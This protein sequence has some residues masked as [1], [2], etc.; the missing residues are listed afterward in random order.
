MIDIRGRVAAN[1][2]LHVGLLLVTIKLTID[3]LLCN[4]V[5]PRPWW[6]LAQWLNVAGGLGPD[7]DDLGWL[8]LAAIALPF[9]AIGVALTIRRLRDAGCSPWLAVL[10][11]LPVVNWVMFV[12]LAIAPSAPAPMPTDA[13]AARPVAAEV[14]W[15]R[16]G[17][18]PLVW[19]NAAVVAVIALAIGPF[20]HY[21]QALFLGAPFVQG[22]VAGALGGADGNRALRSWL[23]SVG[24]VVLLLIGLAAEGLFCIAMAAPIWLAFGLLGFLFG[25]ALQRLER[26]GA[27]AGLL[28]LPLLHALEPLVS[29]PPSTFEVTTEVVV[30]AAPERVWDRLVTFGAMAP[31]TEWWFRA[32][33]AYPT[34]ATIDGR[35]VGAVRRC[36]FNTGDFVEP[37]E[38]WDEPRLLRFRVEQC[39]QP[40]IEWNPLHDHVHAAHLHGFFAARRGQFELLPQDD[41]STLLR[42]TT[43]YVHG[44]HPEGYWRFWSDWLLHSIHRRVLH[45]I[46][47]RSE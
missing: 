31:P 41:G 6:P 37:I 24:L 43:W 34:H 1:R 27:A 35:G 12:V 23:F 45:H 46:R 7:D 20:A 8:V 36:S 40:M 47:D 32:G 22:L 42:G 19:A 26:S 29:P 9:C 25:R 28:V 15:W 44:L 5:F 2:Y 38:V 3:G 30:R 39:P 21:G 13:A 10:F 17:H 18:W 11:V 16:R 14:A 4:F 33:I